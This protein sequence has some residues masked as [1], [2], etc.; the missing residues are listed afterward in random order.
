MP[1]SGSLYHILHSNSTLVSTYHLK[2]KGHGPTNPHSLIESKFQ[3]LDGDMY[4]HKYIYID[5]SLYI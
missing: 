5:I 2:D 3:I 4:R 1:E